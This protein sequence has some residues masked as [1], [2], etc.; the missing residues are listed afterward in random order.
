M[1]K[2]ALLFSAAIITSCTIKEEKKIQ[3]SC[4]VTYCEIQPKVSV[5][6]EINRTTYKIKTSCS[7]RIFICYREYKV[8]DTITLTEVI[9]KD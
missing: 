2:I 6:D 9:L 5:M 7:D 1:K 3:H 8:G 4:K